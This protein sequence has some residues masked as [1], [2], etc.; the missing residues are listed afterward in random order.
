MRVLLGSDATHNKCEIHLCCV[1]GEGFGASGD[2]GVLLPPSCLNDC[3]SI[4]LCFV[5]LC[6]AVFVLWC[7]VFVMLCFVF[8]CAMS[9]VL[10]CVVSCCVVLCGVVWCCVVWCGFFT[11]NKTKLAFFFCFSLTFNGHRVGYVSGSYQGG[12]GGDFTFRPRLC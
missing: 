12:R 2:S 8:C 11:K 10:C 7:V 4:V 3:A 1:L 6:C 5:S 9:C